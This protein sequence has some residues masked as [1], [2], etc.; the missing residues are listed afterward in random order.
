[1]LAMPSVS[2]PPEAVPEAAPDAGEAVATH[3]KS[4]V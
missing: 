2:L 4:D 3:N 1:M